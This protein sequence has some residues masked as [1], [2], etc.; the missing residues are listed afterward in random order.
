MQQI[1]TAERSI[2]E[3]RKINPECPKGCEAKNFDQWYEGEGHEERRAAREACLRP[4]CQNCWAIDGHITSRC[5][6]RNRRGPFCRRCAEPGHWANQCTLGFKEAADKLAKG[7][8]DAIREVRREAE[9]TSSSSSGET[10]QPRLIDSYVCLN[11]GK[12]GRCLA[13]CGRLTP[14]EGE[15]GQAIA[16]GGEKERRHCAA[17]GFRWAWSRSGVESAHA[18]KWR[19]YCCFVRSSC[20]RCDSSNARKRGA[21]KMS[22]VGMCSSSNGLRQG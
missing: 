2:E 16:P 1:A 6:E 12:E 21:I 15:G 4:M 10:E 8:I 20:T 17:S 19:Y 13:M 9:G 3:L 5:G 7:T 18:L 14:D 11:C 22:R